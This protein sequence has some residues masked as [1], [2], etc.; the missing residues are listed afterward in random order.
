[1]RVIFA[2]CQ[3]CGF[4]VGFE[5]PNKTFFYCPMHRFGVNVPSDQQSVTQMCRPCDVP[6]KRYD[7]Y[8]ED[9]VCPL[10]GTIMDVAYDPRG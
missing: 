8:E 10:C 1:M 2:E 7:L 9:N 4:V 5:H 6:M 3:G